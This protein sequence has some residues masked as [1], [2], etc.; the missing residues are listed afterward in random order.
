[1]RQ[2]PRYIVIA[3]SLLGLVGSL[4]TQEVS[5]SISREIDTL[6]SQLLRN[7]DDAPLQLQLINAY[8]LSFN[9]ELA[10]LE[11]LN[12][13]SQGKLVREGK[14]LK[15]TVQ[16]SL[17]Q[18][19]TAYG[20]LTEAYL[21]K[22]S[23]EI[24]LLIGIA[25]YARGE[26]GRGYWE[27]SRLKE[28]IQDL[29][30]KLL[31]LYEKFYLNRRKVVAGAI[32]HALQNVDSV[33][34][35][36]FFPAPQVSVLSPSDNFATEASQVSVVLEVHHS[37]PVQS[38]V[39]AGEEVFDAGEWKGGSAHDPFSKT[40]TTLVPVK[41]GRNDIQVLVSD[42]FGNTS[43]DTVS[44][45]GMSFHMLSTW[46]SVLVD[47]LRREIQNLRNYIPDSVL[48]GGQR[49]VYRGLI[50][51]G[52]SSNAL[53]SFFDRGLYLHEYLTNPVTGIIPTSN[54]KV[55][56]RDRVQQ[57]NMNMVLDEWLVKGATFQSIS[58][59]YCAGDW[60]ISR[61]QWNLTDQ[62]G[63]ATNV[64]PVF[65]RLSSLA[66]GGAVILL[67]GPMDNRTLL[68]EEL[69]SMTSSATVPLEAVILP[70]DWTEQWSRSL[71]RQTSVP[72]SS[73]VGGELLAR[74]LSRILIG[75]AAFFGDGQPLTLGKNPAGL[76]AQLSARL[77]SLLAKK[78]AGE[79][80]S[81][82][83]RRKILGFSTDWRRYNEITRYL[84]NQLS[85]QDFVIRVDEYERRTAEKQDE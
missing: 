2:C 66:T 9:P 69:R 63:I 57:Q 16:L 36:T 18:V 23:D 50:I 52:P 30:G 34:Y 59:V 11:I 60:N 19:S 75:S 78:L 85:L 7:P 24:L 48:V 82:S 44:V 81:E 83:V 28:R 55:L 46:T 20:S 21:A 77:L 32:L 43:R 70:G 76:V 64:K 22:P 38:V 58:V 31:G 79:K 84:G 14:A 33:A 26:S 3:V 49:N 72:G 71:L 47:S 4:H 17:E 1:M 73:D 15:G 62:N 27:I 45:N 74:D 53:S 51:A 29:P 42:I 5:V 12:A 40:L 35:G 13:E 37:R 10:L 56:L 68:E 80:T 65:D 8:T 25:E 54:M 39:V 61:N 67:D 41:E 6:G